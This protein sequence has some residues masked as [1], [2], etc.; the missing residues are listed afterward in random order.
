MGKT[1][2]ELTKTIL[3]NNHMLLELQGIKCALLE[4]AK[5]ENTEARK[6]IIISAAY[7]IGTLTTY[8]CNVYFAAVDLR[9]VLTK[10]LE[11]EDPDGAP[12]QDG[13]EVTEDD[14]PFC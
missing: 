9:D 2:L 5:M 3:D 10:A 8:A 4:A 14:L 1:P 11:A 12:I 6:S 7:R 13:E